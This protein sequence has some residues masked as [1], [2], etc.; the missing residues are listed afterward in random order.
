MRIRIYAT[1]ALSLLIPNVVC[2]QTSARDP[3]KEQ[4]NEE[5]LAAVAPGAVDAFRRATV[6]MDSGDYPQ[7]AQL[8]QSVLSQAPNFAPAMRRLGYC[9]SE[10]GEVDKGIELNED[11]VKIE[12]SPE[13]LASLAEVLAFP[14]AGKK[15]TAEQQERGLSLA[16]EAVA[17]YQGSDDSSYLLLM[18]QLAGQ[19]QREDDFRQATDML[20]RNYPNEMP[21]H[22]FNAIRLAYDGKW[23]G[24]EDEM[25]KAQKMGL[26]PAD[27]QAFLDSGIH[28]R[29]TIWRV[30]YAILY[31]VAGWVAGLLILFLAGKGFSRLTLRYIERADVNSTVGGPEASL[32]RY[33]RGL[34]NVAGVYYYVSLPFVIFLVLAFTAAVVYGFLLTGHIPIKLTLILVVGAIVTVYKMVH[35]LFLRV[36]REEPGWSLAEEEAPGLWTLTR[37]VAE[38]LGTRPLDEIRLTPGTEMAVYER[39]TYTERRKGLGKRILIMGLGLVPGFDQTPFRAVLAHE[40]GH[41]S[42]RDTAGGDVAL[43][44]NRDMMKFGY[45]MVHAGQAVWWNIAFQFLRLYH[46]LFRRI[47]HGATR[48]QEVLADRAAARLYGAMP[49]EE[50]LRHV[51]RRQIE[52]N[53]FAGKEIQEAAQSGRALQNVYA[54]P[55]KAETAVEEDIHK[56]INRETSEDDTHPSPADRFRLVSRIVSSQPPGPSG[57]MWD[58]FRDRDTI[59]KEMSLRIENLIKAGG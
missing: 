12:R 48:L 31:L 47:S 44:V 30:G 46:L 55:V 10:Q 21:T 59:T 1:L 50:G 14:S 34:I 8:F 38:N 16:K 17:R 20:V 6:A 52:F 24:A 27:A 35:S 43:R 29:A 19:L 37:E 36:N 2:A 23:I 57:P 11:A 32:R 4:I 13:N 54:L 41:L 26:P 45:A 53:R 28:T 25:K 22:Y 33:Y 39:G 56:A 18:A 3:K 51:I 7:G 49:F 15:G 9:L 58:L 5:K 40:Y 42:H